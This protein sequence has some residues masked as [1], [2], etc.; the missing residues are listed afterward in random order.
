MSAPPAGD[1]GIG[2]VADTDLSRHLLKNL[3]LQAGYRVAC[4]I[5]PKQLLAGLDGAAQPDAWLL[6][7]GEAD[8]DELLTRLGAAGDAPLLI[9]DELPPPQH[10]TGYAVWQRRLLDQLEELA[11]SV[12]APP[13]APAPAAVWVLA[14]STGGPD[15]VNRFLR[16][17]APGLP[18]ALVYAQHIDAGFDRVLTEALERHGHYA[19]ALGHGEQRLRPGGILVVPADR[20]LRFLPFHRVVATRKP[21]SGPF[22][23]A[24]DQVIA[25]VARLYRQRCGAIIFSG[26]CDDGASGCR[27]LQASGGAV[28]VQRPDCCVSPDMPNAALATGAVDFQGTPEQLAQALSARYSQTP[29]AT[30]AKAMA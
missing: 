27:L 9:N 8:V 15:A 7:A 19:S 18:I 2:I 12:D 6:D 1:I 28:W 10:S 29:A 11:A 16:A 17:L 13:A 25:A 20:Q 3:L 5:A 26:L 22:Q 23:P 14:A 4:C 24:I 21:W 30:R